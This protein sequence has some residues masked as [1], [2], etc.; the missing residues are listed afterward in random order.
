MLLCLAFILFLPTDT[1][2]LC[3][4]WAG[5]LQCYAFDVSRA[6][7]QV[8]QG[9]ANIN[10]LACLRDVLVEDVTNLLSVFGAARGLFTIGNLIIMNHLLMLLLSFTCTLPCFLSTAP[11]S[12]ILDFLLFLCNHFRLSSVPLNLLVVLFP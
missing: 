10:T 8:R 11:L 2:L 6:Y 7:L 3:R 4:L 5:K 1:L 9:S 12:R